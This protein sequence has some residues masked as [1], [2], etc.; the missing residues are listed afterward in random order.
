MWEFPKRKN[1]YI[2]TII[3]FLF[4]SLFFIIVFIVYPIISSFGLS[5]FKWTGVTPI[6]DFIGFGNWVELLKDRIFFKAVSNNFI[7]VILSIVT[8]IPVAIILAIFLDKGGKKVRIFKTTYFLPLLMSTVAVG[9]LFKYIYD[10]QFGMV[11]AFLRFTGLESLAYGLLSNTKI[12]LYSVMAVISWQWI[13]FY[14]IYFVAA[15]ASIPVELHDAAVMDGANENQYFW[16][17]ILP[18]LKGYII[19]AVIIILVGSLK[20]FDLIYVMTEGGPV[21]STE[22]MAT[23]MYKNSFTSFRTGY[24]ATIASAQFIIS[25]CSALVLFFMVKR[26]LGEVEY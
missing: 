10:P 11:P 12:A 14:M 17:I 8:Q 19:T 13:P 7:V 16:K 18:L 1:D 23:Y 21:H 22:L 25:M 2:S 26:K 9:F 6:K 4:P 20:Y 3:I 5:F 24:G 15:L